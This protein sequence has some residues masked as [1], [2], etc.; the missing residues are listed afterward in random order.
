V[1]DSIVSKLNKN[2]KYMKYRK[3][4]KK[5]NSNEEFR[6]MKLNINQQMSKSNIY[7]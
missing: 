7:K 1:N 3:N 5:D 6:H 2:N 4:K